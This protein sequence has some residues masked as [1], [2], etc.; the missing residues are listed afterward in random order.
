MQCWLQKR[1]IEEWNK[2]E[3]KPT[4]ACEDLGYVT[5]VN[6]EAKRINFSVKIAIS[7]GYPYG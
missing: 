4:Y 7:F 6:S 3:Y 5:E 2:I 1:Q